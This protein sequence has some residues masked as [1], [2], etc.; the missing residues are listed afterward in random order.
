MNTDLS[1]TLLYDDV[2][3]DITRRIRE[4]DLLPYIEAQQIA[5][6]AAHVV[7][8]DVERA[9]DRTAPPVSPSPEEAKP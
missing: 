6:S 4:A 8:S 7:L 9:I 1:D 5:A 2:R 3:R